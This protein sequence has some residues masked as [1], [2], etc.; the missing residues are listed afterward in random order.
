MR[1]STRACTT[2]G[3]YYYRGTSARYPL[4]QQTW[5]TWKRQSTQC[6]RRNGEFKQVPERDKEEE[7][8]PNTE[9]MEPEESAAVSPRGVSRAENILKLVPSTLRHNHDIRQDQHLTEH[10]LVAVELNGMALIH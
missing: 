4:R 6:L 7:A 3:N 2:R 5:S 8:I 9:T 10:Y 1:C